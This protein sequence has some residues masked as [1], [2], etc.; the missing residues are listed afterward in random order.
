MERIEKSIAATEPEASD[1]ERA[2][3]RRSVVFEL[4]APAFGGVI[5]LLIMAWPTL[6]TGFRR[7]QGGLGDSRLINF[8]LEHSYR[9]LMGMPLAED[10]WSPP[11][12]FPVQNVATYTDLMLGVAPFYW[13]WRWLA[14]DPH[15]AYQLW[16]LVCWTLNF[17]CCY[18][19]LRHGL[20]ISAFGASMGAYL[21]AF[22]SPRYMSMAHQQLVPQFWIILSLAGLIMLFRQP[23]RPLPAWRWIAIIAF[24]G[25]LVAQLYTAV[26][27]LAFFALGLAAAAGF[28]LLVP[29]MRHAALIAFKDSVLP[30]LVIG[31]VAV[32]LSAPLALRYQ[33]TAATIGVHTRHHVHLPKPLSWVL[34]GNSSRVYG[35]VQRSWDLAEYRGYSQTNGFGAVTLVLCVAGLWLA[36]RRPEVQ[37]IVAGFAGLVLMTVTWPGGWS[38]WWVVRDLVPGSAALRAVARVGLMALFPAA[39]GLAYFVECLAVR[40]RWII[41]AVLVVVVAAEQPHR[42]PSFDKAAAVGRVERIATEV[43]V[44][45]RTFLLVINGPSWDKYLHD[46]AAWAALSTGIPTVNGR[47]GHF[48]PG[49]PFRTPWIQDSKEGGEIRDSLAA[50]VTEDGVA[51]ETAV[52]IEVP[53]RPERK[54]GQRR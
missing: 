11:I 53:P 37:L 25:G 35:K 10:L 4:L 24:W 38:L 14:V 36:R 44:G 40:R 23:T 47:Y 45:A 17:L 52:I 15:T 33:A 13:P 26:Y 28:A 12:F 22:G 49:Y 20:R 18:L 3:S 6:S 2:L 50:W 39:V 48:P 41:G 7:V 54:R 51:P 30:F 32:G 29:T 46:D 27:P 16:M 34:P 31:A 21:F 42:R 5:G 43:P 19:L 1:V 9:W 8:S